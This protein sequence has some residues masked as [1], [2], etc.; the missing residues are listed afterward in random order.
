MRI[1][2]LS[3]IHSNFPALQRVIDSAPPVDA[4]WNLGDT[5]GYGAHPNECM[6]LVADLAPTTW[7]AGN[8]DLAAIGKLSTAWFNPMAAK[9]AHWSGSNLERQH[10]AFIE[11][12]HPA[13]TSGSHTLAHGSPR[14]PVDEYV[15]SSDIAQANFPH[16]ST[17]LCFVGHSHVPR[18]AS[19]DSTTGRS[20]LAIPEP[21]TEYTLGSTRAI[22]N[23]GSVGQPRD[24]D[25]RAAFAIFDD[26]L[27]TITFRRVDY[28]IRSAQSA[29][30]MAGLPGRLADRLAVGR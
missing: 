5:V 17:Q 14:S 11:S 16:F 29:I 13:A 3:D 30:R 9:A 1:L 8:H 28:D 19:L 18:I 25:P 21:E 12:L 2:I 20:T 26:D 22:L 6:E 7:L 27:G 15:I 10:R 24:G 4:V 23:P